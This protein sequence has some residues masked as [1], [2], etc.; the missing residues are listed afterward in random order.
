MRYDKRFIGR[1]ARIIACVSLLLVLSVPAFAQA[2]FDDDRV[3]LQGFYWESYRHGHPE[4]FPTFGDK[5]WYEIV[6]DLAPAIRQGRFDL[7]WLPPPSYASDLSAG[8]YSAGYNPKEYFRLDNNYG[9]FTQH[10]AMLEALLNNGVEPIADIVINHRDGSTGWADFKNPD[11]GTWAICKTDEA[12]QNPASGITGTPDN[13]KGDCEEHPSEYTRHGGTTY[14]Y[15]SFRDIAHTDARVRRDIARYLLQLKSLGYRGWRYDMVHGYHAKWIALYNKLTTP[16]FSVGEYDWGAHNE[17][18]GWIWQSSTNATA[19]GE[20][21][22][23]SSSD[24]FDFT[25]QFSLKEIRDGR[26]FVLYGVGNGIGMVGDTTD[27]LPWKNRAVTFLENHD[28][29]YRTNED[30]TPQE[31]HF[32]DSFANGW[33]VEQAYAHILTHPGVPCVYWKHYFDWGQDLQNKIRAL[34]N[35]RKAAGVHAGSMVFPQDNARA[36][37]VY[38]ARIDGRHGQLY[39]RVGGSDEQ[40]QPSFSG[41]TDYREYAQGAGWKVWVKLPGNPAVVQVGLKPG[42]PIPTY[43]PPEKIPAPDVD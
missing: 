39:V 17:Q 22:L 40:W 6:R 3:M 13:Q 15:D 16:T 1:L 33:Q 7:I 30:G 36:A 11:W 28:T 12:F 18:R 25:T 21:H 14:Q 26:Y 10:R 34:I 29:G 19:G 20:E 35:A 38:A 24:V 9:T 37:G 31:H 2:G 43:M 23:K 27:G 8:N 4:K 32:L 42:L 41:Y 5:R